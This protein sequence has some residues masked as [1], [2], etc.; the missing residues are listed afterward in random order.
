[1]DHTQEVVLEALNSARNVLEMVTQDQ[2]ISL[3]KWRQEQRI[4]EANEV[5]ISQKEQEIGHLSLY[6][7]VG[8][9]FKIIKKNSENIS[10]QDMEQL[11]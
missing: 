9:L 10:E 6:E 4:Q 2:E 3:G 5:Y 8:L 1:M 11:Q 7:S